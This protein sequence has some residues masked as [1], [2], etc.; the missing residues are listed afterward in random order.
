[1]EMKI[2][3]HGKLPIFSTFFYYI[4]RPI[5]STLWNITT[6]TQAHI[7]VSSIL[8]YGDW[9]SIKHLIPQHNPP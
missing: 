1:M 8:P 5:F 7:Y 4:Y 3:L 6:Y 2:K 9:E